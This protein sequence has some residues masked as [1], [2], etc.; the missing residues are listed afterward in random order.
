MTEELRVSDIIGRVEV[1]QKS[2]R[3]QTREQNLALL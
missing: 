1:C 2:S 3:Y